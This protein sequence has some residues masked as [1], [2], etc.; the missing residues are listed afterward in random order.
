[1]SGRLGL[2]ERRHEPGIIAVGVKGAVWLHSREPVRVSHL[3]GGLYR[4]LHLLGS[5]RDPRLEPV[6][7]LG[8]AQV[9]CCGQRSRQ[10]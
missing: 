8:N 4:A 3:G 2:A 9:A 6:Q 1:M 10:R 7:D 5:G